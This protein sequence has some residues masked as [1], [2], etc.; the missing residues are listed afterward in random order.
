MKLY[1]YL[2]SVGGLS[3]TAVRKLKHTEG[4]ILRNGE[5]VRTIDFISSGDVIKVSLPVAV[6]EISP[7]DIP[8]DILY[9]DEDILVINKPSGLAMHPT[10][11][12]QG[13]TLANAVASY[14]EKKEKQSGFHAVGRLDKCTSGVVVCALNS[15]SA[16]KLSA[17]V[18]KEYCALVEGEYHGTGTIDKPIYRPDPN[19]T[20]RAAGESGDYA[21][22]HWT[23]LGSKNGISFVSIKLETGRTHQIRVHFSSLGTPLCGDEMY[24][25][26]CEYIKRAALH[27]RKAELTHPVTGEKMTFVAPLPEDMQSVINEL[28]IT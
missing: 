12:H 17:K 26:S 5:F 7:S 23:A 18:E 9:E 8:L 16:G 1:T 20:L 21:I 27:C 15:I 24:G 10:H 19:K 28:G 3:L 11:N 22:T 25:G 4:G 14:F 13:D 6:S 2:R